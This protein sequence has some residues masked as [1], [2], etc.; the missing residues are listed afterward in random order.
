M[1]AGEVPGATESFLKPTPEAAV[2][3]EI[4]AADVHFVRLLAGETG[5]D[6]KGP[7]GLP[8]P[9]RLSPDE[10]SRRRIALLEAFELAQRRFEAVRFA[11]VGLDRLLHA[12]DGADGPARRPTPRNLPKPAQGGG[13]AD[14]Y[15]PSGQVDP[16]EI[17]KDIEE[18][19]GA[20]MT[21][22]QLQANA[23]LQLVDGTYLP[24]V[25]KALRLKYGDAEGVPG[26][27]S[28]K[29]GSDAIPAAVLAASEIL[30]AAES[31]CGKALGVDPAVLH[32][33]VQGES[34]S[35]SFEMKPWKRSSALV[36]RPHD[37]FLRE[38]ALT[39]E[40]QAGYT[41]VLSG[42]SLRGLVDGQASDMAVTVA[43]KL[44]RRAEAASGP[45]LSQL[46]RPLGSQLADPVVVRCG[47][48]FPG[49]PS[50]KA[51]ILDPH[52]SAQLE[53]L[54]AGAG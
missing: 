10:I 18:G 48:A 42:L 8:A 20:G 50:G 32:A 39:A 28:C 9:I 23:E 31:P 2:L 11:F 12:T 30:E 13:L 38:I 16:D 41:G 45:S 27:L 36:C 1:L 24:L 21:P 4:N 47:A 3:N 53:E 40:T 5:G 52:R 37:C 46:H 43:M 49:N 7:D 25:R 51:I 54:A 26:S 34:T 29:N 6:T 44:D 15:A 17:A 33:E 22:R 19:T 35:P 14:V